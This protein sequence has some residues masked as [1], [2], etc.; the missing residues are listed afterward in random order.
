MLQQYFTYDVLF[1]AQKITFFGTQQM[2][3]MTKKTLLQFKTL[4]QAYDFDQSAQLLMNFL[5]KIN[6]DLQDS[7]P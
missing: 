2:I 5:Q 3:Q 6:K 1:D 7:A 4:L